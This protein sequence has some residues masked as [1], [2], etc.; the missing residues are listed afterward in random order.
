MKFPCAIKSNCG[1]DSPTAGLTVEGKDESVALSFTNDAQP[2]PLRQDWGDAQMPGFGASIDSQEDADL[3]A[4]NGEVLNTNA[5][6]IGGSNIPGFPPVFRGDSRPRLQAFVPKIRQVDVPADP[7]VQMVGRFFRES[8]TQP[9]I[10]GS[11]PAQCEKTCPDGTSNRVELPAG[12]ILG[13]SQ[14]LIDQMAQQQACDE[15]A[16]G[17][18]CWV[19]EPDPTICLFQP[20]KKTTYLQCED[21]SQWSMELA[22]IWKGPR[23]VPPPLPPLKKPLP[24]KPYDD[25]EVNFV[26]P[27]GTSGTNTFQFQTTGGVFT[28]QMQQQPTSPGVYPCDGTVA[29]PFNF[30][31]NSPCQTFKVS[32]DFEIDL[33]FLGFPYSNKNFQINLS[34]TGGGTQDIILMDIPFSTQ[35][36]G[37]FKA[38]S[39]IQ[40]SKQAFNHLPKDCLIQILVIVSLS[41]IDYLNAPTPN[42]S[43]SI[44][45]TLSTE[46]DAAVAVPH[47]SDEKWAKYIEDSTRQTVSYPGICQ[48][49]Q[50]T[51]SLAV[52]QYETFLN[53]GPMAQAWMTTQAQVAVTRPNGPPA[54]L[55]DLLD[56]FVPGGKIPSDATLEQSIFD[57]WLLGLPVDPAY[58]AAETTEKNSL[59]LGFSSA[60]N[61]F[62]LEGYPIH[63]GKFQ[64]D[65]LAKSS[66]GRQLFKSFFINVL[67][68]M[69]QAGKILTQEDF[70][71]GY[72][73]N[74]YGI[75]QVN[76]SVTPFSLSGDGGTAPYEFSIDG[77]ALPP[78]LNLSPSGALTGVPTQEGLF[79]FTLRITDA[80]GLTCTMDAAIT[81]LGCNA[82]DIQISQ[83][84][85]SIQSAT[86]NA[87][88]TAG[89]PP[90]GINLTN[91]SGNFGCTGSDIASF[92]QRIDTVFYNRCQNAYTMHGSITASAA[93]VTSAGFAHAAITALQEG[94]FV[95]GIQ[96][97][98]GFITVDFDMV[99]QPGPNN[100][101]FLLSGSSGYGGPTPSPLPSFSFSGTIE[102]SL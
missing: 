73:Q 46:Y 85:Q 33:G 38:G 20:Y 91:G 7:G 40:V 44:K 15:A 50:C 24:C 64:F 19:S 69:N 2:P 42:F 18:C 16:A 37:K 22:G 57:S 9:V 61:G 51:D 8:G 52:A 31:F 39:T 72:L 86:G 41:H 83:W 25:N 14:P 12:A 92:V 30:F 6:A 84:N 49:K 34:A 29:V 23:P 77:G 45:C 65:V 32:F 43:G 56:I 99:L 27:A 3:Q 4:Q 76:G 21:G 59:T 54:T 98:S 63:T 70:P 35:N 93:L 79:P 60:G 82:A 94:Q 5:G 74:Q 1:T 62:T 101:A 13:V 47:S 88:G 53:G 28:A 81:I 71:Q 17:L 96:D 87:Q 68:V 90:T 102:L 48:L 80:L 89:F 55:Q 97:Q 10:L 67:G 66:D 58:A 26:V 100:L 75:P 11:A 95:A 36:S 78:G